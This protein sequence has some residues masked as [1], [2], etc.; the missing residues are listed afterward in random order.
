MVIHLGH[1]MSHLITMLPLT[2]MMSEMEK[3]VAF[4]VQLPVVD[5]T[6]VSGFISQKS[7]CRQLQTAADQNKTDQLKPVNLRKL[8]ILAPFV[9]V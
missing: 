8:Q 4:T 6:A 3:P 7:F 2:L 9:S 5:F 1:N